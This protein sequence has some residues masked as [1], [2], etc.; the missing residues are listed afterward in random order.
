MWG[1]LCVLCVVS[2]RDTTACA[3]S[4]FFSEMHL[5]PQALKRVVEEIDR[6]SLVAVCY[7]F[8]CALTR[9]VLCT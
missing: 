7:V 6:V 3:L 2:G 9:R 5:N 4:W 8:V 1:D